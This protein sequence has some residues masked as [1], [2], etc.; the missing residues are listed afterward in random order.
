MRGLALVLA[1][2]AAMLGASSALA[3]PPPVEAFG[4]VP[5]VSDAAISPDGTKVA[6]ALNDNNGA[7]VSVYDLTQQQAVFTARAGE[8]QELR[9]VGWA[10]DNHVSLVV[11]RAMRPDEVLPLNYR[12]RGTPGRVEFSRPGVLN[13]ANHRMEFLSTNRDDNWRDQG[14][15]LVAPIEGDAGSG[16][17]VGSTGADAHNVQTIFR[18]DLDTGIVHQDPPRGANVNTYSYLVG[19][20]GEVLT[21]TD[22][23][24]HTNRWSLY[25]YDG[26][27]PRLLSSDISTTGAPEIVPR[28]L[29][30]DGRIAALK[31]DDADAYISLFAID[32]ATGAREDIFHNAGHDVDDAIVDPWTRETVGLSWIEDELKQRFF[33]PDLQHAYERVASIFVGSARI[34]SWSRDRSRI[35]IYG[36][37]GLDGGAYYVF[38]TGDEHLTRI[39]YCYPELATRSGGVREAITYRARDG[40]RI[41]AYLTL[42]SDT[43]RN[44]PLVLLVHGGPA[45]RDTLNFDWWAAFLASR[46]YAVLQPNYRGSSGYGRAWEHAGLGEWGGLM[47]T[48]VE[49]GVGP[50]ARSGIVDPARV[51]IVGASY[52]G[53]AALAGAT[54]TPDR[55]RCAVSVAGLSD[56]TE[57][58]HRREAMAGETSIQA[59]YWRRSIGDRHDAG[60]HLRAISPANLADHVQIPV[61]LIHGTDDTVVPIHQ[62]RL[63]R[64]RL[65]AAHKN[66]RYVELQGDDHWLSNAPTRA[67]M[68]RELESF[69]GQNLPVQPPAH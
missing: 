62:S 37:R 3:D 6:L 45:A 16:R 47:Q 38:Q 50:L 44:L 40:T 22:V 69:L 14:A 24:E 55:Y 17:L 9:S 5:A 57:F 28:G 43:A 56:L 20:H 27:A 31:N 23:D 59:D 66:V 19:R 60:D 61:L 64:D 12:Y 39:S 13:L 7:A 32:R 54:L 35:L 18:V 52:G 53:Y 65:N 58:V 67:Q 63:M 4:R 41:P 48:D 8:R 25:V 33:E 15:D 26:D 1:A 42:P 68:L 49:D 29:L 34:L 11:T 10:D 2:G 46:G 21:R 30:A 36:E 51:C